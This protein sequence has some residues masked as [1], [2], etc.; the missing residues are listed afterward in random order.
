MAFVTKKG[1]PTDILHSKSWMSKS[2]K[3]REKNAFS[4]SLHKS[5]G[6]RDSLLLRGYATALADKNNAYHYNN[7]KK[8]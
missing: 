7:K 3:N 2:Y 1:K 6:Y 5:L 8:K 4:K